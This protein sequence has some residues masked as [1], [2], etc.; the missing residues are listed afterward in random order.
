MG[1][2]VTLSAFKISERTLQQDIIKVSPRKMNF[3][4]TRNLLVVN[5]GSSNPR[6]GNRKLG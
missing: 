2:L 5:P 6:G 4:V 3:Y 1:N